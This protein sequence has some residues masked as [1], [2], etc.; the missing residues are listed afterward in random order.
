M[1]KMIQAHLLYKRR[2]SNSVK[3][4]AI[5]LLHCVTE[6]TVE[7]GRVFAHE[8]VQSSH[9]G[10]ATST[11][12]PFWFDKLA[13]STQTNKNVVVSVLLLVTSLKTRNH[14]TMMIKSQQL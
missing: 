1:Y 10:K 12:S 7:D 6:R 4:L 5:Q 11:N 9:R 14:I 8:S 3:I 2:I 13:A